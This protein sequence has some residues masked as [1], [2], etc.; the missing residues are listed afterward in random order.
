M[1]DLRFRL[2]IHLQIVCKLGSVKSLCMFSFFQCHT[3][4]AGVCFLC[5]LSQRGACML[6]ENTENEDIT[7]SVTEVSEQRAPE[8]SFPPDLFSR[9]WHIVLTTLFYLPSQHDPLP[10]AF[11]YLILYCSSIRLGMWG[12]KITFIPLFRHF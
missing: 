1:R 5:R 11:S 6:G 3:V 4:W 12:F 7:L 10:A 9:E 2:S 8:F